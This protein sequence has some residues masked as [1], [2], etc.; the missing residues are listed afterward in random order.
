MA[1]E[2]HKT[3]PDKF[4]ATL[5]YWNWAVLPRG[6]DIEP[7]VSVA[8]CLYT[9]IYG[10]H[11]EIRENEMKL[12]HEW[13]AKA[14]A[15]VFLWNYYHHPMEIGLIEKWKCFPNVMVHQSAKTMR[16]FIQDGIRGI[17]VCGE[18]DMLETYVIAKLWDDPSLDVD[19]VLH[20]FF[21]LY[22]GH[23]AEPMEAFYRKLEA[24]ASDPANYAGPLHKPNGIDWRN[25]AWTTLGTA[26]EHGNAR[27]V[28]RAGPV[29]CGNAHGE[30]ACRIV[31][32]SYVEMDGGW[33]RRVSRRVGGQE[34]TGERRPSS[35][36]QYRYTSGRMPRYHGLASRSRG[37][38]SGRTSAT[39]TPSSSHISARHSLLASVILLPPRQGWPTS[40]LPQQHEAATIM[41]LLP[42]RAFT[43]SWPRLPRLFIHSTIT[44]PRF[45]YDRVISGEISVVADHEADAM[46]ERFERDEPIAGFVER[47]LVAEA[48]GPPPEM[49]LAVIGDDTRSPI[50][51][52]PKHSS[53]LRRVP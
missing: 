13:L 29:K 36:S 37:T 30:A 20:E 8:P 11:D 45:A 24:L 31:D 3:H 40:F 4:I 44:Q 17:F 53:R 48:F 47:G 23:A 50:R 43:S 22:F 51:P 21:Q 10:I 16:M 18:Q 52:A 38:S 6:F 42:A 1:R 34:L 9:C 2:V 41:E 19:A 25:A 39:M 27:R 15:P 26:G 49:G 7:N 46:T 32:G 33:P 12:Y 5:A 14:K 35:E 28:D